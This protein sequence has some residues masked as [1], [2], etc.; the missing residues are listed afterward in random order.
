MANT[1]GATLIVAKTSTPASIS[2]S[3]PLAASKTARY[4]SLA[5]LQICPTKDIDH[6]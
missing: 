4:H 3:F 2:S 6:D 1:N 5:S